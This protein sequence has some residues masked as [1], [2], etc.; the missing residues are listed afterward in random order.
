MLLDAGA[1]HTNYLWN[2]GDTTQ[3]IYTSAAGT[4]NVTVGNGT[5]VS[6]SNSL[7]FDGQDDYS[8]FS[9]PSNSTSYTYQCWI[10]PSSVNGGYIVSRGHNTHWI[11]FHSS[12]ALISGTSSSSFGTTYYYNTVLSV[13]NWYHVAISFDGSNFKQYVDCLLYTSPSPRD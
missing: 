4:Y 12:G 7:S 9:N 6:N 2:T 1:G 13:D 5:S 11:E 10:K 8:E 3:T